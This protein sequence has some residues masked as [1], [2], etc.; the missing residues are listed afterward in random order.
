MKKNKLFTL[1]ELLIVIVII[2][3]LLS[4]LIPTL[5]RA[6]QKSLLISCATGQSQTGKLVFL[7]A[8]DNRLKIPPYK[9]TENISMGS[10]TRNFF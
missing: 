5:A 7:Y 3:I 9:L 1:I 4:L 10:H 6:K 2:V 8:K